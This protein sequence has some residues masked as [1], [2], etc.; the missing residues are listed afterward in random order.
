MFEN[1]IMT[2]DL[3]EKKKKE[4]HHQSSSKVV[5]KGC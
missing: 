4:T 3:L 1:K 2:I 5:C